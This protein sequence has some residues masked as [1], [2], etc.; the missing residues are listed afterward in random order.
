MKLKKTTTQKVITLEQFNEFFRSIINLPINLVWRGY[1][2]AVFLEI[3]EISEK[4]IYNTKRDKSRIVKEGQFGLMIEWSWRVE[5]QKS[6]YFGSWSTD[7]IIDNRLP[8]LQ[9]KT[10][11]NIEVIGR[12]PELIIEISDGLWLHSFATSESQP[13]WCLFLNRNE[14]PKKWI[15]SEKGKLILE[16]EQS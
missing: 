11:K 13:R 15:I 1:G 2:S 7:R 3:G 5:K 10:I 16:T 4:V 6:I 12:L 14:Q 9:H 8:K